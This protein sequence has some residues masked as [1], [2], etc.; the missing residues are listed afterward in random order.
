MKTIARILFMFFV[1][2]A[3]VAGF[4]Q[5]PVA[6]IGVQGLGTR[7]SGLN[8]S[9]PERSRRGDSR[10]S[11]PVRVQLKSGVVPQGSDFQLYEI[12]E[13]ERI[14]VSSQ[15]RYGEFDELS[16]VI[17]SNGDSIRIFEL[18]VGVMH[19]LPSQQHPQM[20]SAINDSTIILSK[21]NNPILH[22]RHALLPPP[23]GQAEKWVRSGFIHPLYSPAGEVLTWVQPP[24]HL[25]HMGL[26]NPWTRV[27]WQGNHTDFWN[28][29][30]E[31]GT[32]RFKNIVGIESGEVYSEF[33]VV[34]DHLAF[35]K[36]KDPRP[37]TQD[38]ERRKTKD[39]RRKT[40]DRNEVTVLSEEWI[41]RVWNISDG[42]FLDF[43]SVLTNVTDDTVSLDAYRY[44]GGLGYRATEKWN[45][46]NSQVLTSEGKT[47]ENGDATR[48]KWCRVSGDLDGVE[49]GLLFMSDPGN[50][51]F[52]Q[53]MRIWPKN[54][55]GGVGHQ[56]FEFT[57]IREKA[58]ILEAGKS[59][60]QRYRIWINEGALPAEVAD[61]AWQAYANKPTI[62][63][64]YLNPQ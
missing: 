48:A 9:V 33:R 31:Q 34:Q 37:K 23:P 8:L 62:K 49:T 45:N 46:S 61:V 12:V 28:L 40:F 7:D 39:E 51:D 56:Y 15:I 64:S 60:S 41:V 1:L 19:D 44:G 22:Y 38:D 6:R 11:V 30:D 50:Y 10:I 20:T 5:K 17:E 53:P 42:Y 25:H 18:F 4:A 29:G 13:D 55:I 43:T 52:P 63:I 21:N 24:D 26:W 3:S 58:W 16:W 14:S 47:W 59:Y 27:T 35:L 57:P 2:L 54:S 36:T 32:V